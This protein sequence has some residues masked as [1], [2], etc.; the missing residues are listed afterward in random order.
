MLYFERIPG[1]KHANKSVG[2]AKWTAVHAPDAVGL[3]EHYLAKAKAIDLPVWIHQGRFHGYLEQG[4][5]GVIRSFVDDLRKIRHGFDGLLFVGY[6]RRAIVPLIKDREQAGRTR[7]AGESGV[8]FNRRS[9]T[10]IMPSAYNSWLREDGKVARDGIADALAAT[11]LKED[12]DAWTGPNRRKGITA[13]YG[14]EA[15]DEPGSEP[16][17]GLDRVGSGA[18]GT[19]VPADATAQ[20]LLHIRKGGV[21]GAQ[22]ERGPDIGEAELSIAH[23]IVWSQKYFGE[24][25]ADWVVYSVDTDQWMIVLLAMSTGFLKA[26]GD[27]RVRVTVEKRVGKE[28]TYIYVNRVFEAIRDQKDGSESAWPAVNFNGWSPD[29]NEKVRLFVLLYLLAGCDFLPALSGLGFER[30]WEC[31]LKSVRA[32]GIFDGSIF[33]QD[34]GVWSVHIGGCVKLLATIFYF[35]YES[36]F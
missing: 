34:D 20:K 4:A 28:S 8:V 27:G 19:G 22:R 7:A 12:E 26:T 1:A 16:S 2:P 24:E 17:G 13:F 30:M 29:E 18:E 10:P 36:S 33:V 25:I 5:E 32:T 35:K 23:F 21:S 31:A 14:V 3:V 11:S 15:R 6:D 9:K